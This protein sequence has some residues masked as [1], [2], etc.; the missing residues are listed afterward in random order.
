MDQTSTGRVSQH[1]RLGSP[2]S[3]L[4][5][6]VYRLFDSMISGA[7]YHLVAT[8]VPLSSGAQRVKLPLTFRQLG[9]VLGHLARDWVE[10]AC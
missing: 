4:L 10:T 1:R 8:S 6:V 2:T 5:A 7:R 3:H 9:V